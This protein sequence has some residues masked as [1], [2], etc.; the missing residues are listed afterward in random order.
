MHTFHICCSMKNIDLYDHLALL[1]KY[2]HTAVL[3]QIALIFT[4][5]NEILMIVS[6]EKFS[7]CQLRKIRH[8]K[9]IKFPSHGQQK[10]NSCTSFILNTSKREEQEWNLT[11]KS[12]NASTPRSKNAKKT[13]S[14]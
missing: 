10:I 8:A 2:R 3:K 5:L 14:G 12:K 6:W 11:K 9:K 13:E 1:Q 7:S 4:A